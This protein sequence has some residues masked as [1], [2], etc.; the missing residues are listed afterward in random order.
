MMAASSHWCLFCGAEKQYL[1]FRTQALAPIAFGWF[2]SC[3]N[4]KWNILTGIDHRISD[5]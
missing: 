3:P 5:L 1:T 4:L 2:N